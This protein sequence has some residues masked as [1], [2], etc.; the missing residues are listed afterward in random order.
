[1][2]KKISNAGSDLIQKRLDF[3]GGLGTNSWKTYSQWVGGSGV[4]KDRIYVE[5][6]W[7]QFPRATHSK[8]WWLEDTAF[9][10]TAVTRG[11]LGETITNPGHLATP[12]C[13]DGE[14]A[15]YVKSYKF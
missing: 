3:C 5:R 13:P 11:L 8:V 4:P 2:W 9:L 14:G 1:M 6:R 10:V 7:S 15:V 12:A